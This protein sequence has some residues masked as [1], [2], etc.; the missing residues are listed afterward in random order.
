MTLL[1]LLIFTSSS[2][3]GG[4]SDIFGSGFVFPKINAVAR[5]ASALEVKKNKPVL[6][7][8]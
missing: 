8:I 6:K 3:V 5:A 4:T 7:K 2:P 1:L